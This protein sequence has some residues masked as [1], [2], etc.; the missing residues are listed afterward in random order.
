MK[1]TV[2]ILGL[3]LMVNTFNNA[4][5]QKMVKGDHVEHAKNLTPEEIAKKRTDRMIKDLGL[6]DSQAKQVYDLNLK[7]AKENLALK[8]E[9][10]AL[11]AK[12]Q[13]NK[14]QYEKEVNGLLTK[15]QLEKKLALEAKRKADRATKKNNPPKPP[16]PPKPGQ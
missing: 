15:E 11:K 6:N 14:S 1:K 7:Q 13:A 8:K 9:R 4:I 2:V 16:H 10:E 12:A 5:A 3:L